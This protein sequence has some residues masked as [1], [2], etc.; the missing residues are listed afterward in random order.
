MRPDGPRDDFAGPE[1]GPAP[2]FP[3]KL[4]GKVIKGFGRGSSEVSLFVFFSFRS[5]RRVKSK[6]AKVFCRWCH[7]LHATVSLHYFPSPLFFPMPP[8]GYVPGSRSYTNTTPSS[9]A[10][11]QPTSPSPASASAA[12]RTSTQESTTAGPAS[13]PRTPQP[14]THQAAR[15]KP[16]HSCSGTFT[17]TSSRP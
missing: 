8:A 14:P 3:L 6:E 10:S 15:R 13:H 16:I 7:F 17:R 4:D 9:S 11:P 1:S 5:I 2:P 12:K